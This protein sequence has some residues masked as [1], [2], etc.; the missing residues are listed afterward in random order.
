MKTETS[1]F[2]I[3]PDRSDASLSPPRLTETRPGGRWLRTLA[4]T[5]AGLALAYAIMSELGELPPLHGRTPSKAYADTGDAMLG[6]AIAPRAAAHP[7]LSGFHTLREARDAFAARALLARAAE[8]SIDAQYYIW[9]ADLTGGLLFDELRAA[10]DR[11]V[12]VRLLLDD[13]TT[14]GMDDTLAALDAHPG[15]ELRLFN[16]HVLRRVRLLGFI[17]DFRRLNR[18]MHNK[19]FTVDNQATIVGGRNVGDEYFGAG[20]GALFQDLDVLAVGPV[21]RDVSSDF[22]RYWA[23]ASAYPAARI[24]PSAGADGPARVAARAALTRRDP[25]AERYLRAIRDRPFASE[26]A[27]GRL[28]LDWAP[29]RMVS[30]DPAKGLGL[31]GP[32]ELLISQLRSLLGPPRER[33]GLVSAYFVPMKAGVDAFTGLARAGVRVDILTNSLSATDVPVV[34][35]GYAKRRKALLRADVR[36]WELRGIGATQSVAGSGSAGSTGGG[37]GGARGSATS[38]HAKTFTVDR[39]RAFI[40][41]FNFDPR[42]ARLNTELGFVIGSPALATGMNQA[43]QGAIPQN[44]YEVR[45]SDRGELYW[46]E[47]RGDRLLR[48]DVEPGTT[49]WQRAFIRIA[50]WLPIEWLL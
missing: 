14:A 45:L 9:H 5:A 48:H 7:G 19:S 38:L 30:D 13:N 47:R 41:S 1:H 18:R 8:R 20:D 24:L 49:R 25:A 40:G 15:V 33:L 36:L 46:I 16:P 50:S 4:W 44:A 21:V 22:D 34:H 37:S 2:V 31:A 32:G 17:T 23:S 42:S 3:P 6:R 26:L 27:A 39:T 28:P 10:A 29:V 12:R 11:G 43:F 35:S